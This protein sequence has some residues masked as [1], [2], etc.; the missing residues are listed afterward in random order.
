MKIGLKNQAE[1]KM[2]GEFHQADQV[3]TQLFLKNIPVDDRNG[4]RGGF[5]PTF[6]E[7]EKKLIGLSNPLKC[8]CQVARLRLRHAWRNLTYARTRQL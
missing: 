2:A 4:L 7:F 8:D 6:G 1:I 3:E 5:R